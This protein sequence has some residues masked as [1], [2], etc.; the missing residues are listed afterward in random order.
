MLHNWS[1]AY[2][3]SSTD[4]CHAAALFLVH[5]HHSPLCSS[6]SFC[7]ASLPLLALNPPPPPPLCIS[8]TSLLHS[9]LSCSS[10]AR[11]SLAVRHTSSTS[12]SVSSSSSFPSSSSS[13]SGGLLALDGRMPFFLFCLCRLTPLTLLCSDSPPKA[14]SYQKKKKTRCSVDLRSLLLYYRKHCYA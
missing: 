12:S 10:S 7:P 2:G 3:N 11:S 14:S 8:S 1:M 13:F 5:S 6:S 4:W 9:S